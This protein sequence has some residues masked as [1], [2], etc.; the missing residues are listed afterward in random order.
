MAKKGVNRIVISAL[1]IGVLIAV[2][3][4]V[5][6]FVLGISF[7]QPSINEYIDQKV[8]ERLDQLMINLPE[9]EEPVGLVINYTIGSDEEAEMTPSNVSC[10]VQQCEDELPKVITS[11]DTQTIQLCDELETNSPIECLDIPFLLPIRSNSVSLL[12]LVTKTDSLGNVTTTTERIQIPALS[13]FV[14]DVSNIDFSTGFIEIETKAFSREPDPFIDGTAKFDILINNQTI[15]TD[16]I[17]FNVNG[18][19]C[20]T[21]CVEPDIFC[22]DEACNFRFDVASVFGEFVSS[23]GLR[24]PSFTFSFEENIDKFPDGLS[25]I[26]F[27][28]VNPE[29][30]VN[31]DQSFGATKLVLFSMDIARDPNQIVITNEEGELQRIYLIDDRLTISSLPMKLCSGG[32]C[33]C[34]ESPAMGDVFLATADNPTERTKVFSAVT[35]G[36][37][38]TGGIDKYGNFA[39]CFSAQKT[40]WVTLISRNT[41][42]IL[43]FTDPAELIEIST[44]KSQK[45]YTFS[46]KN[47][48]LTERIRVCN[49][50]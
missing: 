29:F 3:V 17:T 39:S 22:I 10:G 23:L 7:Q 30:T 9:Q 36:T 34:V 42:Y 45:D 24:S 49:F 12:S 32:F 16:S 6:F 35:K 2:I 46:C 8:N 14:E 28:L 26:E 25:T 11:N 1:G 27:V 40:T 38:T 31:R 37:R 20:T 13:F 5:M 4:P 47:N 48:N 44:P 19:G 50:P 33:N 41:D 43:L 15:L 21:Q 18:R